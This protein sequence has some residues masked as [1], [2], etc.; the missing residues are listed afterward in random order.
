MTAHSVRTA[1]APRGAERI[2]DAQAVSFVADLV[3]A[4]RPRVH[5]LLDARKLRAQHFDRGGTPSFD[6]ETKSI[7]E[8]DWR[9]AKLP[10]DLLDRRV[11]ITG[12]VDRKMVINALNSGAN[13]FMADFEDATAPTW[14]NQIDG[15]Q[16][17]FDAV[18]RTIGFE[19][20]S[21]KKKYALD[22]KTA[23]LLV[24][25]RGWHLPEAHF[26]VDG[27]A[28]PGSLVDFG[29]YFF[30]NAK[31]ALARGTGPY[32]YLPKLEH[33]T[34]ARLW[35]DVFIAAQEKLGVPQGSIKA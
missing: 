27:E 26:V 7:R 21:S 34:E 15:Q 16:N 33:Y 1:P 32:F 11:E 20:P 12:P 24:R 18:R 4:F 31:E 2:L 8:G 17:L 19:D 3:R 30:H 29:F 9:V 6:P 14:E 13:V 22:E 10:S 5:A 35:N 25:P 23:V 28:S